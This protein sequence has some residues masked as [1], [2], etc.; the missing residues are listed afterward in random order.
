MG[1][2]SRKNKSQTR[3]CMP[4][5]IKCTI[6]NEFIYKNKR[7][8][9]IQE[10]IKRGDYYGIKVYRF[11]FK[12]TGCKNNISIKTDP[13]NG[14]YVIEDGGVKI[15]ESKNIRKEGIVLGDLGKLKEDI[16]KLYDIEK[17]YKKK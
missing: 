4:F 12:C 9:T 1:T 3:F 6:C 2:K 7:H 17:D 10:E 15:G 5:T 8:N 13:K 11:I 16:Y 14:E